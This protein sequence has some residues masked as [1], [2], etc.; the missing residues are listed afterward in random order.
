[1]LTPRIPPSE[2]VIRLVIRWDP[3]RK[4]WAIVGSLGSQVVCET[5]STRVEVD[6]A[7]LVRLVGALRDEL[8][9]WLP[10]PFI[11]DTT[12]QAD[13]PDTDRMIQMIRR[14]T[15]LAEAAERSAA[16]GT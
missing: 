13:T 12:S 11:P 6:R 1:M 3:R 5:A 10:L 14:A 7:D 4:V 15:E 16:Q 2:P 8:Q 9:S